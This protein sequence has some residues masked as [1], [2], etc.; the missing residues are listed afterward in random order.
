MLESSLILV[1]LKQ[2]FIDKKILQMCIANIN[3][4]F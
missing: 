4:K 3:D 2:Q 1:L